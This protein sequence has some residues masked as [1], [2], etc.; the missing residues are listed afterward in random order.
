MHKKRSRGPKVL[1]PVAV[2]LVNATKRLPHWAQPIHDAIDRSVYD[3]TIIH[4]EPEPPPPAGVR[5]PRRPLPTA[6]S[7]SK[8]RMG[9]DPDAR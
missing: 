9:D 2:L 1:R 5:E 6:P 7:A 3:T 8:V 4:I